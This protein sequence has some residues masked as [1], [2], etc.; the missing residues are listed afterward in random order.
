MQEF[1]QCHIYESLKY[2][3]Q[4]GTNGGGGGYMCGFLPFLVAV[5]F[6][7]QNFSVALQSNLSISNLQIKTYI[8][9]LKESLFLN[10]NEDFSANEYF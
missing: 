7:E 9:M 8:V 5:S 2:M 3:R 10:D 6:I 4:K 1:F